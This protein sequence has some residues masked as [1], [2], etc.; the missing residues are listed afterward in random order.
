MATRV[1]DSGTATSRTRPGGC[2]SAPTWRPRWRRASWARTRPR[3]T[4]CRP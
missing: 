3:S 2:A 4:G 1:V